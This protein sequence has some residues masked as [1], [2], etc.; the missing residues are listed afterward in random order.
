MRILIVED[1]KKLAR[2]ISRTLKNEGYAIDIEYNSS[3][4]YAMA[5]T[6]PYDALIIDRMMPGDFSDGLD[7][8][9]KLRKDGIFTPAIVLTAL[10]ETNQK[11][12]GLDA[13]ADD[14]LAKP[15]AI[16]ELLAR[17]RAILRRPK[18]A[19]PTILKVGNLHMDTT[20]RTVEFDNKK[21]DLTAKEYALLQYLMKSSGQ[22]LSKEQIMEHVWNFDADILPNTVE[23]YIKALRKK[24]DEKYKV[25]YIKTVRGIGYRL[26]E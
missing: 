7:I 24:I 16:D 14:Y 18:K 19:Q 11:I 17:L 2:A 22:T 25:K 9:K 5:S 15:F 23:A 12:T 13:G 8:L 4:G 1:E 21:I 26:E 20:N 10:G 6:Q 3:E